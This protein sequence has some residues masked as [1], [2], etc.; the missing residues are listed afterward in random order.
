M[1]KN[2]QEENARL[3]MLNAIQFT[4]IWKRRLF[5]HLETKLLNHLDLYQHR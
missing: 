4:S 5:H 1:T 2:L 3:H